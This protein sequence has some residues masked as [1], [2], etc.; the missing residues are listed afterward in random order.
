M[1][2]FA[3]SCRLTLPAHEAVPTEALL[4]GALPVEAAARVLSSSRAFDRDT[5]VSRSS[6]RDSR[7]TRAATTVAADGSCPATTALGAAQVSAVSVIGRAAAASTRCGRVSLMPKAPAVMLTA[8]TAPRPRSTLR[9]AGDRCG[10]ARR[11]PTYLVER[12]RRTAAT[13]GLRES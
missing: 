4:V 7:G 8:A 13:G 12:A 2:P 6:D 3:T 10:T 9:R 11:R 1:R 5:A